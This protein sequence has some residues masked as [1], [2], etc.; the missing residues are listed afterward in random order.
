MSSNTLLVVRSL[1]RILTDG[2]C[3]PPPPPF[4]T[5]NT[6][7]FSGSVGSGRHCCHVIG[8]VRSVA[9]RLLFRISSVCVVRLGKS[10]CLYRAHVW[11]RHKVKSFVVHNLHF[12][13]PSTQRTGWWAIIPLRVIFSSIFHPVTILQAE[14][15][16]F[17]PHV[18]KS[19][20]QISSIAMW[21][22]MWL[23][24]FVLTMDYFTCN[25]SNNIIKTNKEI[26]NN[27]KTMY[28]LF[29]KLSSFG[30]SGTGKIV[31]FSNWF[32]VYFM[33]SLNMN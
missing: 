8:T 9:G 18:F 16:Y 12:S 30:N 32:F 23:W 2:L 19:L 29:W 33:N 22:C 24:I 3:Y 11:L 4:F 27:N 17:P 21:V 7:I 31:M 1:D 25:S 10:R 20:F 14:C 6:Q 13:S 28:I 15:S 26:N 5:R